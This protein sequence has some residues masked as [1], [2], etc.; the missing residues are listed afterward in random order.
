MTKASPIVRSFNAGEVSVLVEGRTDLDRYPS[1]NRKMLNYVAAP[2]G[3][4]IPRSGT[5]L[6][7][8]AYNHAK[9]SLLVPFIFSE[10]NA[11]MLEFCDQKVRFHTNTGLLVRTPVAMTVIDDSPFKFT[12]AALTAAGGAIGMQVAFSGFPDAYNLNAEVATITNKVGDDYTVDIAH[13]AMALLTASVALVYMIDSPYAEADLPDVRDLQSL[14]VVYLV[15]PDVKPYKLKRRDT[16]DWVFEEV[17][18]VDGPYMPENEEATTLTPSAS[19]RHNPNMTNNTTPAGST[20][21]GSGITGANDF[22]R[23]FN[24][25]DGTSYW[26]SSTSQTGTLGYQNSVAFICNGYSIHLATTN[27]NTNY[28]IKDYAPSTWTFEGS[29]DGTNYTVLDSRINYVL[30][31]NNKSA[32]FEI[33]NAT[34]YAY[35]RIVVKAVTRNGALTPRIHSLMLRS[36]TSASLTITASSIVGINNDTGFQTTDI[37]R[38]IR[39]KGNDGTWRS[40][41]ITARSSTTVVTATLLG[42]PFSSLDAVTAW[43][44]GYWSD[45]TGYPN[46]LCF[47]QDRLWWVGSNV[48]P[49]MFAASVTG[50]Y[51]K[52]SQT[53]PDGTVLDT[54]AIVGRLNSRKLSRIRWIVGSNKGLLMGTGSQEFVIS[55]AEG[56]DKTI[57]PSNVK[58]NESSARGSSKTEPVAIDSQVLYV[59]RSGRTLR[60]F[61]YVYEADGYK[62]PSMST[63]ASHLGVSPFVKVTYTAEPYSIVWLLR[64]DG[65]VKGLTYNR[66]ENVVGWHSHDFSGGIVE[67]ISSI[68]SQD[69]LQD[70]LWLVIRRTVDGQTRR[71]I[72]KMTRF[73]DFD[74]TIADAHYVDCAIRYEGAA[75]TE[76]YGLQHLE[77]QVVYGLADGIPVGPLTVTGGM[78]TIPAEAENIIIGLGFDAEGETSRLENGA[79]DGTAQGKEKRIHCVSVNVWSSYGGEIGTWNEDMNV[80]EWTALTYPSNADE[81]E[82]ITLFSGILDPVTTAPGYE[83]QGSVAF[84]RK[85]EQPLPFN[86][87][88]LMPQLVTQDR[89]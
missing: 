87:V 60:E 6:M 52:I 16:Y 47:Y 36:T 67:S 4:A 85:K 54:S 30:F 37:G 62:S 65:L 42:E 9:K 29:N 32:F 38:L 89:G 64:E 8:S 66:D 71:Y 27:D 41:R 28:T 35:Y 78:V 15:H 86:I 2:Q 59:Q 3:P 13:P 73:W 88:G 74:M 26:E 34:A 7:A 43:R 75:I 69:Q 76:F 63:L 21:F 53:E 61:A 48:A 11:L 79:Q 33:K 81:V 39:V 44:L 25:G 22:Y 77:G 49:D 56:S 14:D 55:T 20:A 45:T 83:K 40:L 17:V 31:T 57:T 51:E 72:E 24:D 5:Y 70:E 50:L 46:A 19:G 58:A 18:F 10:S 84:R 80:I 23:A 82:T 12:S 68:P 1:S